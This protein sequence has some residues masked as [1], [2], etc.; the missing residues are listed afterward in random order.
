M[1]I[2]LE[3]WS[4]V[5][6]WIGDVVADLFTYLCWD[7]KILP[8]LFDLK[9]PSTS[10]SVFFWGIKLEKIWKWV[11]YSTPSTQTYIPSPSSEIME[12]KRAVFSVFIAICAV[13]Y[14]GREGILKL[15]SHVTYSLRS[16]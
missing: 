15:R 3:S 13:C 4:A 11:V 6:L 9:F 16:C 1:C 8:I 12:W 10:S 7:D 14:D 5:I 2:K